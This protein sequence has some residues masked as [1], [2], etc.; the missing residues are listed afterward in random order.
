MMLQAANAGSLV[1][2]ESSGFLSPPRNM[3]VEELSPVCKW[4]WLASSRGFSSLVPRVHFN[5]G[6]ISDR[7]WTNEW[8]M[9]RWHQYVL[10]VK[11]KNMAK[12]Q[13]TELIHILI[14]RIYGVGAGFAK[15]QGCFMQINLLHLAYNHRR[16][17][18]ATPPQALNRKLR[19]SLKIEAWHE[20]RYRRCKLTE[21]LNSGGKGRKTTWVAGKRPLRD[22]FHLLRTSYFLPGAELLGNM[23]PP[24]IRGCSTVC[25]NFLK[26]LKR[27]RN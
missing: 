19:Y 23:R 22:S 11:Q 6:W 25:L 18:S 5:P 21:E 24:V 3:L 14:Y 13:L 12:C 17:V 1:Q 10:S 20:L 8:K 26:R 4:A 27:A 16:H 2:S 9:G 7:E 15:P